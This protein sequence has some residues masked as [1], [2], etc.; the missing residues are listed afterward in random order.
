MELGRKLVMSLSSKKYKKDFLKM[1]IY[2]KNVYSVP[3]IFFIDFIYSSGLSIPWLQHFWT[4]FSLDIY[5]VFIAKCWLYVECYDIALW[6]FFL[7]M[8]VQ[9]YF[10]ICYMATSCFYSFSRNVAC[11]QQH[12]LTLHPSSHLVSERVLF[13]LEWLSVYKHELYIV[14]ININ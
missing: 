4:E 9:F 14:L 8:Q 11:F 6:F 10:S 13:L 3:I 7:Y 1:K 2:W 5:L 12:S